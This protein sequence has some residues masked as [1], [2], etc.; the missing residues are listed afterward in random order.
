DMIAQDTGVGERIVER[1][2]LASEGVERQFHSEAIVGHH[3]GDP[4]DLVFRSRRPAPGT[5]LV[6]ERLVE[7]AEIGVAQLPRKVRRPEVVS[8]AGAFRA[9]V[10]IDRDGNLLGDLP[11]TGLGLVVNGNVALSPVGLVERRA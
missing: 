5:R 11:I 3:N 4:L 8:G 2:G 6:T 10:L 9:V 1:W 7:L